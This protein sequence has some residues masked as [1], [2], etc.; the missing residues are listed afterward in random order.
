MSKHAAKTASASKTAE[1]AGNSSLPRFARFVVENAEA[2]AVALIMAL[3]VR[4]FV[5]EAFKIPSDSM[6]PTLNGEMT[7]GDRVIVSKWGF[8]FKEPERWDVT[9][10]RYPL[11]IRRNFIKRLVGMPG[12]R[13]TV[14]DGDIWINQKIARKSASRQRGI[15]FERFPKVPAFVNPPD[16]CS[17]RLA[18][19]GWK[20]SHDHFTGTPAAGKTIRLEFDRGSPVYMGNAT[21]HDVRDYRIRG[22]AEV[23]AGADLGVEMQ[24]RD[25]PFKLTLSTVAGRSAV[26]FPRDRYPLARVEEP[27]KG[28]ALPAGSAID[29]AV[30]HWDWRFEVRV[31]GEVWFAYDLEPQ[32]WTLASRAAAWPTMFPTEP[33]K[34]ALAAAGGRVALEDL[35]VEQDLHYTQ[36]GT[37]DTA[38][39]VF[40]GKKLDQGKLPDGYYFMMGDNS[41]GSRDSRL[42]HR[43]QLEDPKT[44]KLIWGEEYT[45]GLDSDRM[46]NQNVINFVDLNGAG[47]SIPGFKRDQATDI[48]ANTMIRKVENYGLIPRHDLV[49]RGLCVFWPF[50]PF[51]AE[52]R[53]KIVR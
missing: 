30:A 29:F 38:D 22:E 51:S 20:G 48:S 1:T 32:P 3:I 28:R 17:W 46:Y 5:L 33:N 26:E 25:L 40:M 39:Y 44:G 31:D 13:L 50:P 8:Q 47:Y 16:R 37:F 18:D 11:D 49:G 24:V 23:A 42:W 52:F 45:W 14:V 15:W 36:Q 27:G 19:D 4:Q 35:R 21:Y 9:V 12:E 34:I 53:P 2:L 41:H 10:F 43:I 7:N 6:F